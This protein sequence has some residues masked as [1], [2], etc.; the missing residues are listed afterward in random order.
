M[1]VEIDNALNWYEIR[2]TDFDRAK[3]FYELIFDYQ[4][5]ENQMGA[6]KMGFLLHD[7][8]NT[9][10]GGAIVHN[11]GFYTPQANGTLVYLNCQPDL[12]IVLDRVEAGG[13][14]ILQS[15]KRN[16]TPTTPWILGSDS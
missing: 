11:P 16:F 10:V 6:A 8:Q 1:Q 13:V 7:F 2:V 3:K 5:P 4:M 15:K 12:H 14:K 9:E